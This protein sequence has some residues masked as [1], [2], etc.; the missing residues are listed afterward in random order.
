MIGGEVEPDPPVEAARAS[1][2]A[3]AARRRAEEATRK[4]KDAKEAL[5]KAK[6][7]FAT[8]RR[9]FWLLGSAV[10]LLLAGGVAAAA[11]GASA[12][13]VAP[14]GTALVLLGSASAALEQVRKARGHADHSACRNAPEIRWAGRL[15]ARKVAL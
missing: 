11:L 5:E 13:I 1:A 3:E 4:V 15:A 9:R 12:R 7:R 8:R 2:A 14:A 6:Q 10:L